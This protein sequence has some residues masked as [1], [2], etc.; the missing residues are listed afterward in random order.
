[1]DP[2][3]GPFT[4]ALVPFALFGAGA[5]LALFG[6]LSPLAVP[7]L[8]HAGS[9]TVLGNTLAFALS[10]S[11]AL[12]FFACLARLLLGSALGQLSLAWPLTLL[13]W[14]PL[15]ALAPAPSPAPAAG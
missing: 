15:G 10:G 13:G 9:F 3:A 2:L 6:G 12:L 4:L 1:L 14:G 8:G 11:F 7:L 5:L